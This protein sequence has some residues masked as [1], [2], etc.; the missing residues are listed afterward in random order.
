MI[1]LLPDNPV[2]FM[3]NIVFSIPPFF[4]RGSYCPSLRSSFGGRY[5]LLKY[6]DFLKLGFHKR[7]FPPK[8]QGTREI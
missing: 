4:G 7:Y 1:V 6:L 8:I 3:V 5:L 2:I